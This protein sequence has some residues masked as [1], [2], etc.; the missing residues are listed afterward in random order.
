VFNAYIPKV[1]SAAPGAVVV[2]SYSDGRQALA[3][4]K[5]IQYIGAT[6]VIALDRYHNSPGGFEIINS[7]FKF[8]T[9]Y[10]A[11]QISNLSTASGAS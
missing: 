8:I 10:T 11:A 4:G 5:K 6:G 9:A 2:H 1:T 3:Q 7:T